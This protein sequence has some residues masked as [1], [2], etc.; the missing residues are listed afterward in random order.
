[1]LDADLQAS[2]AWVPSDYGHPGAGKS[3]R[4]PKDAKTNELL[5]GKTSARNIA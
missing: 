1:M 3:S 2:L 4:D 5:N